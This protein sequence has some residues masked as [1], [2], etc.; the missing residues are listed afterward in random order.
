MCNVRMRLR[1][2]RIP[3]RKFGRERVAHSFNGIMTRVVSVTRGP[4]WTRN[5][6]DRDE[7][8]VND[9]AIYSRIRFGYNDD[10]AKFRSTTLRSGQ[11]FI[12][13]I[14]ITIIIIIIIIII[15]CT[16][17]ETRPRAVKDNKTATECDKSSSSYMFSER[18]RV[19]VKNAWRY[20]PTTAVGISYVIFP[21]QRLSTAPFER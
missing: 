15:S 21:L 8:P 7:S 5:T 12:A 1:W 4:N 18:S 14:T 10:L 3:R 13:V 11:Y 6:P 19:H 17:D 2:D 20:V 9:L 16:V